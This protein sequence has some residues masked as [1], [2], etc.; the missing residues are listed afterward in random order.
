MKEIARVIYVNHERKKSKRVADAL[1]Q[2]ILYI[3]LCCFYVVFMLLLCCFNVS[4]MFLLCCFYV[5]Q[6]KEQ[7]SSELLLLRRL[8]SSINSQQSVPKPGK[9]A[10]STQPPIPPPHQRKKMPYV[11]RVRVPPSWKQRDFFWMSKVIE[12]YCQLTL[13]KFPCMKRLKR[14]QAALRGWERKVITQARVFVNFAPVDVV[15][16]YSVNVRL[17]I[18]NMELG[19]FNEELANVHEEATEVTASTTKCQDLM[20]ANIDPLYG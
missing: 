1:W 6:S 9:L 2:I 16:L 11:V 14:V 20:W 7:R 17:T 3:D 15:E 19:R 18:S 12:L 5:A 8:S 10:T 13:I 4:F